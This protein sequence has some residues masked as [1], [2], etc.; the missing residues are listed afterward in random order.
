MVENKPHIHLLATGGTIANPREIEGYLPGEQLVEEIPELSEVADISVTDISSTGSSKLGPK[1][2]FKLHEKITSLANSDDSPD[3]FV[4]TQGSNSIEETAYFLNLTL[5]IDAPV[6]LAAAQRNHRLIGND[7][8]RNLL[9][10]VKVA[11]AEEST[12]RGAMVVINDEIHAARDVSKIV[13]GRP[14]A[15]S[16][17]NLGVLGLI[18]KRDNMK[19]LRKSEQQSYPNTEFDISDRTADEYPDIEILY[20]FIG[21]GTELVDCAGEHTDGIVVAGFPTGSAK[22]SLEGRSQRDAIEELIDDGFPVVMSHR[23]FDGWPYPNEQ[24][25]WGNTLVP[26]KAAILLS[27]GLM[28]TDDKSDLQRM[29]EIY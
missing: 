18:D 3:G 5:D 23:G 19:F 13:S 7:G 11:S 1:I 4:V 2:W 24:Y 8:D 22:S 26:Q 6:T 20:S 28:H 21:S 12:G 15:W 16:S 14:D 17:G 25:I 10:A 29:F 27:L 9:D